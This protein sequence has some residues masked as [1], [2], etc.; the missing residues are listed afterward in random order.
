MGRSF[1]SASNSLYPRL[2]QIG[3]FAIPT[4]GAL[5]ALGLVAALAALMQFAR[6]MG[7]DPNK[8]WNFAVI[9]ILT[10]L[11]S[12]RLLLVATAFSVFRKHPFWVLGLTA[13]HSSWVLS[14]AVI[15]GVAAAIFYA[16][17]EGLSLPRVADCIAPSSALALGI[18]R[19]GAFLAGADYGVPVQHAFGVTYTSALARFWYGT[20]LGIR[21]HPVQIYEAVASLLIFCALIWW[22]PRR[23]QDG[24]L[25][26]IWLFLS[27]IA[28]FS[29]GF[30]RAAITGVVVRQLIFVF[31][32]IVSA[33]FLLRRKSGGYTVEDDSSRN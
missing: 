2:F 33:M 1:F 19:T 22:L 10:T 4:Y 11:I 5:I 23:T 13:S 26:G 27:G 25:F 18:S 28:G 31:F 29:W 20:P 9:G 14:V 12:A 15:L 3:H 8:L 17:A 7:L 6:R 30:Y 16:L 24:E 32:V 21:L